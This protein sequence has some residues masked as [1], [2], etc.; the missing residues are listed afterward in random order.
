MYTER[1]RW[2]LICIRMSDDS[3]KSAANVLGKVYDYYSNT[4]AFAKSQYG[5][6]RVNISAIAYPE[7][8]CNI[9]VV[10]GC[11]L[12]YNTFIVFHFQFA[13]RWFSFF[14]SL[15]F[16]RCWKRWK[17]RMK[18]SEIMYITMYVHIM[19]YS[20]TI[21]NRYCYKYT[22]VVWEIVYGGRWR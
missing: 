3:Y 7:Q 4:T 20:H 5:F 22:R 19:F 8:T 11:T 12:I 1:T 18:I 2:R 13:E 17:S 9:W 6:A 14:L 16:Q 10:H 21:I 15:F